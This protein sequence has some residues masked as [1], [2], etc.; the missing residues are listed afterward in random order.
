M[1]LGNTTN[2]CVFRYKKNYDLRERKVDREYED[3]EDEEEVIVPDND[4]MVAE[5]ALCSMLEMKNSIVH[6]SI[7]KKP[8]PGKHIFEIFSLK[9]K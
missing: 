7:S 3:F 2:R 4:K 6:S 9:Y 8:F 1:D 5:F